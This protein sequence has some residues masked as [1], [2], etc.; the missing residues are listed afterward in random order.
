MT[1][2]ELIHEIRDGRKLGPQ[3]QQS[4]TQIHNSFVNTYPEFTDHVPW[5]FD[6]LDVMTESRHAPK[7]K[8]FNVFGGNLL[9]LKK[10]SPA[11]LWALPPPGQIVPYTMIGL[12]NYD[13]SLQKFNDGMPKKV[14]IQDSTTPGGGPP[15][16]TPV[17]WVI[18]VGGKKDIWMKKADRLAAIEVGRRAPA[19]DPFA[20]MMVDNDAPFDPNRD[21]LSPDVETDRK[22]DSLRRPLPAI[23]I[24]ESK[25][26]NDEEKQ[27]PDIPELDVEDLTPEASVP[28]KRPLQAEDIA[29]IR[30]DIKADS[31]TLG[32]IEDSL[33]DEE[34][35][36]LIQREYSKRLKEQEEKL[37]H[38]S[39]IAVEEEKAAFDN[40]I[41][42]QIMT[43][44]KDQAEQAL[45]EAHQKTVEIKQQAEEAK[46]RADK[47]EKDEIDAINANAKYQRSE[48][49]KNEFE[50]G[51]GSP[52]IKDN[53][54]LKTL[55]KKLRSLQGE[56]LSDGVLDSL[57]NAVKSYDS[58]TQIQ[59]KNIFKSDYRIDA[60]LSVIQSG[61]IT[62]A[63]QY[64][65]AKKELNLIPKNSSKAQPEEQKFSNDPDTIR[66]FIDSL[67][68]NS[69]PDFKTRAMKN[70]LRGSDIEDD[71]WQPAFNELNDI[72]LNMELRGISQ[73][74][75]NSILAKIVASFVIVDSVFNAKGVEIEHVS[76]AYMN[77]FGRKPYK[78]PKDQ[79]P[80]EDGAGLSSGPKQKKSS[81]VR[82]SPRVALQELYNTQDMLEIQVK[83]AALP[84]KSK[85][86]FE[87]LQRDLRAIIRKI[88]DL[89]GNPN[90]RTRR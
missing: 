90:R 9:P 89:G 28:Y 26:E 4:F 3:E 36:Q 56:A 84:G 12:T 78:V 37:A 10:R 2:R 15:I 32:D 20:A 81:P 29:N 64:D 13:A 41:N 11:I 24:P 17:D 61:Q 86:E 67:F 31:P 33:N 23:H 43:K 7:R 66:N 34:V 16:L 57:H 8:P 44:E 79:G 19:Q 65:Y 51:T 25:E 80:M 21:Y 88:N 72:L 40:F 46:A 83:A 38:D 18:P 6:Q 35:A 22:L 45:V 69:R 68:E 59:G 75:Y 62:N 49:E 48:A 73:A 71:N 58:V 74:R 87:K 55:I 85:K 39:E 42:Q 76:E 30:D 60:L 54:Y 1:S 47:D 14:P 50:K 52:P 70:F 53:K 27:S 63:A 82:K 77:R 5:R